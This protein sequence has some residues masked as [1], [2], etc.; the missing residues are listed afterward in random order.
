MSD[1]TAREAITEA[2]YAVECE[3][4]ACQ[5]ALRQRDSARQ[6]AVRLEQELAQVRALLQRVCIAYETEGDD[7]GNWQITDGSSAAVTALDH[8]ASSGSLP[9]LEEA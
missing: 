9:S 7:A 2:E 4:S 6:I 5:E 3:H 1:M 8:F